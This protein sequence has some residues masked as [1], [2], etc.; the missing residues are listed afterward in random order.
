MV[1]RKDYEVVAGSITGVPILVMP[2]G[3]VFLRDNGRGS[4]AGD[5]I[6][7]TGGYREN[8]LYTG[9]LTDEEEALAMKYILLGTSNIG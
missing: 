2:V 6:G 1:E 3:G 7:N 9:T 5:Y 4:K 8:K